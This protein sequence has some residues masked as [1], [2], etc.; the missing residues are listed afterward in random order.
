MYIYKVNVNNEAINF[1][2]CTFTQLKVS[3]K[4]WEQASLLNLLWHLSSNTASFCQ[5]I[6][7]CLFLTAMP[8]KNFTSLSTWATSKLVFLYLN[9]LNNFSLSLR[10]DTLKTEIEPCQMTD[11]TFSLSFSHIFWW[12]KNRKTSLDKHWLLN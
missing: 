9:P 11:S 5:K 6:H 1:P 8:F 7:F 12:L 3:L 2:V 10:N 4:Y